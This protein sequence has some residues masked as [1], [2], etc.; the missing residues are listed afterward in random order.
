MKTKIIILFCSFFIGVAS[1]NAQKEFK[2][3][4]NLYNKAQQR[5]GLWK[6]D[7][8]KYWRSETYY[9]NGKKN[10]IYKLFSIE[11]SELE[12]FGEY[13]NDTITGT[14]YYFS[15]YGHLTMSQH[16]FQ[17]NT[18][19]TPIVHHMRQKELCPFRCYCIFYYPN[20]NK[21]SEGILLWDKDPESDFTFEYGE[22]KYYD[23]NERLIETKVFK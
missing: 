8:N 5:E 21:K 6:D 18:Y 10:G 15:N 23:E 19:Q 1:L 22:W 12:I 9:H 13:K 2:N 17:Q 14:W 16:D 7:I 4:I 11:R 3:K 20:G